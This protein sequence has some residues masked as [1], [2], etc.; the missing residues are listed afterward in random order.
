MDPQYVKADY[1]DEEVGFND[2]VFNVN[3]KLDLGNPGDDL[4]YLGLE[5]GKG[6]AN[7]D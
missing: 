6:W 5:D 1:K 7:Y 3:N 4:V 2:T